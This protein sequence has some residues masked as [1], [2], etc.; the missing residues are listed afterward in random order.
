M[1]AQEIFHPVPIAM[2][3][4]VL[5]CWIIGAAIGRAKAREYA[6]MLAQV[7]AD[8]KKRQAAR[9]NAGRPAAESVPMRKRGRPRKVPT[10]MEPAPPQQAE[11]PAPA[12]VQQPAL[13]PAPAPRS[14]VG[15]NAFAGECVAFSGK[16]P[17]MTR[18]EA[19][20]AV[21]ANGGRAFEDMPACT[22]LLVLGEHPGTYKREKARERGVKIIDA[23]R[24]WTLVNQPLTLTPDE[25]AAAFAA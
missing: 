7:E 24:F 11:S 4:I 14:F 19:I 18:A 16:L 9:Q 20:Q 17:G 8:A 1:T 21:A 15:N 6:A 22:T 12:P 13:R 25:F 2:L 5:I 3:L 10:P 23:Q